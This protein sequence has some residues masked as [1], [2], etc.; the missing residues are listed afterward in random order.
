MLENFKNKIIHGDCMKLL[1]ALADN[2]ID[3]L[4][5]DP[6]Y[7][8]TY[9]D[10]R[11]SGFYKNEGK[12]H[13]NRIQDSFGLY[14]DPFPFLKLVQPKL[15]KINM[16]IW[17]NRHLLAEYIN[18]AQKN[19]YSYEILIWKKPNPIP[20]YGT[21]FLSDKEYCISIRERGSFFN[22]N[23]PYKDYFTIIEHPVGKKETKHPTEKPQPIFEKLLQHF[24]RKGDL[25]LDPFAGSGT[26][27]ICCRN[28]NRN[29][30]C[31]E[32]DSDYW[33]MACNRINHL[34]L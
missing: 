7:L 26:T 5:T 21:H 28:L 18:F 23:L 20:A 32:K 25:V 1:P 14:F 16:C 24:T 29:F 34:L 22:Q 12:E 27:A 19:K 6:P 13:L 9:N 4:L 10:I 3:F 17:T 31:I 15:K 2:S 33:T 30:L 8:F 11:G